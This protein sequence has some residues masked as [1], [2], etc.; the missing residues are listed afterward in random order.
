MV[1]FRNVLLGV[2]FVFVLSGCAGVSYQEYKPKA[3]IKTIAL[4]SVPNPPAYHAMDFGHPGLAFG[5]V[6][7]A[8]AGTKAASTTD[9]FNKAIRAT[10]FDFSKQMRAALTPRLR[11]AGF[12]V[13][14]VHVKREAP[15]KLIENYSKVPSAGADAFLD[16]AVRWVGYSTVNL[17]DREFRPHIEVIVRLVSVRTKAVFYSEHVTFGYHNPTQSATELPA[18]RRYFYKDFE[19]VMAN[20]ATALNGLRQGVE[21]VAGHIVSQLRL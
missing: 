14:S 9:V 1:A 5:A 7:G 12:N 17:F 19:A 8:V 16:I 10:G 6:G 15:N 4:I 11:Q 18:E 3:P 13:V 21:A 20:K 2:G